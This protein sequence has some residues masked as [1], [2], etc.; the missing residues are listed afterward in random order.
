MNPYT[1]WEQLLQDL[2]YAVRMT[3]AQP[4]FTAMATLSLALGIGANTAIFSFMEQSCC[5]R[6]QSQILGR[7]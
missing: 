4:L 1:L 5:A 3:A 7:W 6:F 2:R